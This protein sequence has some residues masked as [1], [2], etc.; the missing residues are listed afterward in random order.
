MKIMK[1][2]SIE[3]NNEEVQPLN[4]NINTINVKQTIDLGQLI[5]ELK[6]DKPKRKYKSKIKSLQNLNTEENVYSIEDTSNEQPIIV[7]NTPQIIQDSQPMRPQSNDLGQKIPTTNDNSIPDEMIKE[8]ENLY[9]DKTNI[10]KEASKINITLPEEFI[11]SETSPLPLNPTPQ[12]I[13][14]LIDEIYIDNQRARDMIDLNLFPNVP[15]SA[16]SSGFKSPQ[17]SISASSSGFRLNQAITNNTSG[18]RTRDTLPLEYFFPNDNKPNQTSIMPPKPTPYSIENIPTSP[19]IQPTELDDENL[20][21]KELREKIRKVKKMYKDKNQPLPESISKSPDYQR[22]KQSYEIPTLPIIEELRKIRENQPKEFKQELENRMIK[23]PQT[24]QDELSD[25]LIKL[26]LKPEKILKPIEAKENKNLSRKDFLINQLRAKG[27]DAKTNEK[28][29]DLQKQLDR[30]MKYELNPT[31]LPNLPIRLGQPNTLDTLFSNYGPPK[32]FLEDVRS[33]GFGS[34][35]TQGIQSRNIPPQSSLLD[36]ITKPKPLPPERNLFGQ[37]LGG[38]SDFLSSSKG[39]R[40]NA[41]YAGG[42]LA[43]AQPELIPAIGIAET[44]NQAL[45]II[46][47]PLTSINRSVQQ[48]I[49]RPLYKTYRTDSSGQKYDKITNKPVYLP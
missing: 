24:T 45:N 41:G 13:K 21:P 37:A 2:S 12:Q 28:I 23:N 31:V 39:A 5:K 29:D 40:D 9:L 25:R 26:I 42:A 47:N 14:T 6:K 35:N 38:F 20:T 1:K 8:L 22:L 48:S 16:S 30:V 3:N 44:A 33:S 7:R 49:D 18:E 36:K 32:T 27:I 19:L 34:N 15:I 10:I 46:E 17:T 11:R 43:I 4:Q